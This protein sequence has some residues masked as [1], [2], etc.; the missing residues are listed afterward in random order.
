VA[1]AKKQHYVPQ[2][3]LKR[4]ADEK[5]RLWVFDKARRRRFKTHLRS[6]ACE[7]YFYDLPLL[8]GADES[9]AQLVERALGD[10]ETRFAD[11]LQE[12]LDKVEADG[13][14]DPDHKHT[15][16]ALMAV[17]HLRSPTARAFQVEMGDRMGQVLLELL[18]EHR[19]PELR[20]KEY[21]AEFNR[22]MASAY[23]AQSMFGPTLLPALVQALQRHIWFVGINETSHPLYTSDS[24]VVRRGHK[25]D[26]IFSHSG[27]ASEG[28]E[29]AL[30]LTPRRVLVLCDQTFF[31]SLVALDCRT[32]RLTGDN[33]TYYNS[34]QVFRSHSQLYSWSRDFSLAEAICRAHPEVRDPDRP[35]TEVDGPAG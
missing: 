18:I 28:I 34:L 30:P 23:Q 15:M 9:Q 26:A 2:F 10:F 22:D 12:F 6:G 24:P 14:I 32:V 31:P 16:S 5:Q 7:S 35:R 8:P 27:F 11:V 25:H 3:Y 4:F 13:V 19:M 21:R 20:G 1:K 17:Q 33:V 29:I